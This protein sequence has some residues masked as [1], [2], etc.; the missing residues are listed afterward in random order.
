MLDKRLLAGIL[1]GTAVV[2]AGACGTK[3]L[4]YGDPNS[5][6]VVMS[7]DRW[8][9]VSEDVYTALE[10]TI[11]TVGEERAF[12]VTYQQPYDQYWPELR[13]FRQM[14]LVG[15]LADAWVQE[16]I[17]AS[18]ESITEPGLYQVREV[19]SIDQNV[20]LAVLPENGGSDAL[21]ELLPEIHGQLDRLYLNYA[22]NRMYQSG[23]DSALADTLYTE[24]GFSLLLPEVYRWRQLDSL[25]VF[26]N[27]NPDPSELIREIVVTWVSPS[28]A[29]L[30]PEE[31]LAWRA[32]LVEEYYTEPQDVRTEDTFVETEP[33][34]GHQA[35]RVQSQWQNPPERN[36]PAGGPFI[37]YG[38]TCVNQDRTYFIDAWLYAPGKEKYEYMIQLETILGT[39]L[40]E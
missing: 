15:T 20:M 24:A 38:V 34:L 29:E 9:E 1:V 23:V 11:F 19:W 40:C 17:D 6:I 12:T 26:R 2:G 5:V 31:L 16:V 3:G 35:V 39:F 27:D 33:F 37:T 32:R 25:Y 14:L 36:W 4:S 10:T 22:R 30:S 7:A 21:R 28:P 13:R 8:D 18:R